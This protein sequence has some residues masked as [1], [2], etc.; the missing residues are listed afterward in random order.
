MDL[1][2]S[3]CLEERQRTSVF[4]KASVASWSSS[5]DSK[6]SFQGGRGGSDNATLELFSLSP[7]PP[8]P[9][10]PKKWKGGP[11]FDSPRGPLFG[12]FY[13]FQWFFHDF[14]VFFD[15]FCLVFFYDFRGFSIVF[16]GFCMGF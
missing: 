16:S 4:T 1:S 12:F 6:F 11:E 15:V 8:H 2:S 9:P 5:C 10:P 14:L 3:P 7:P 13:D